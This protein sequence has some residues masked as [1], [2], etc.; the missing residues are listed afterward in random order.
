MDYQDSNNSAKT[1]TLSTTFTVGSTVTP[2]KETVTALHPFVMDINLIN[3]T[4]FNPGES[5][6]F[7][8]AIYSTFTT[9]VTGTVQYQVT[10]PVGVIFNG[11]TNATF[12]PGMNLSLVGVTTPVSI[13]AGSL[14]AEHN[15]GGARSICRKHRPIRLRRRPGAKFSIR[16]LWR[17]L[18]K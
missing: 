10:G 17:Q 11:I 6:L 15:C 3:R 13:P 7:G 9:P 8:T 4:S 1:S 16:R 5:I 12:N 18:K 14:L 2:L